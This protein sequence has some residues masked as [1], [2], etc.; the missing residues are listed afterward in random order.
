MPRKKAKPVPEP[1]EEKTEKKKQR[2]GGRG[3]NILPRS[4]WKGSISFGLVNV[5]V[6]LY[7]AVK[8]KD[9]HFHMLHA[10]DKSRIEEQ[11]FCSTE[12]KK[13][14]RDEIVKG[15]EIGSGEHVIIKDEEL[16]AIAPKASRTIDL[17]QFSD[18]KDI[19]PVFFNR[20]YYLIPEET[21]RKAYFL[22]TK[23]LERTQKV[24]I[25]KFVMRKK[26][27][28]GALRSINHVVYLN[29]MNYADEIVSA[30]ELEEY[31][32]PVEIGEREI[33]AAEDLIESLSEPFEPE[34]IHND[35]R[36]AVQELIN[37][38][39]EGK[40]IVLA[41]AKDEKKVE[42]VDLM[43]ALKASLNEANTKKKSRKKA[44]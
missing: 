1:E 26:E 7:P 4:M 40:E 44:A 25:A 16:E 19:D 12:H 8:S 27:Y 20:P 36:E 32:K 35:Y 31:F 10:K 22:L 33:K 39:V 9:I 41:P 24:G 28:L 42:V 5:P 14:S 37:E 6:R 18:L 15:Y 11:I 21:A 34:K 17:I 30:K 43:A 38:K 13:I 3:H 2:W 29:T 23:A